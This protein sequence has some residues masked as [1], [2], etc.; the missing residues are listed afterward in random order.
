VFH[1]DIS[2]LNVIAFANIPPILVTDD[3]SH[4]IIELYER[5][6]LNIHVI[7][8]TRDTLQ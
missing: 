7:S 5:E 4:N 2:E 3:V 8:T 1:K 6:L